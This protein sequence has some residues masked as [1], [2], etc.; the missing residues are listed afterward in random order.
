[1]EFEQLEMGKN[2]LMAAIARQDVADYHDILHPNV[3]L[4]SHFEYPPAPPIIA[5]TIP[6]IARGQ[7]RAA[8]R[9][10]AAAAAASKRMGGVFGRVAQA[11][12]SVG[13]SAGVSF[14]VATPTAAT[15]GATA[16]A[17]VEA[18][19]VARKA[20]GA[21]G[22]SMTSEKR[23]QKPKKSPESCEVDIVEGPLLATERLYRILHWMNK[24]KYIAETNFEMEV[25]KVIL[26]DSERLPPPPVPK[27]EA[28]RYAQLGRQYTDRNQRLSRL[29][30]TY[31]REMLLF[32]DECYFEDGLIVTIHRY[33]LTVQEML[34]LVGLA[35]YEN[36]PQAQ[37]RIED[38]EAER[39]NFYAATKVRVDMKNHATLPLLDFTFCKIPEP[40]HL[41]QV[42]PVAGKL[43]VLREVQ[44]AVEPHFAQGVFL[45]QQSDPTRPQKEQRVIVRARNKQGDEEV[46]EFVEESK[47]RFA[48]LR[49]HKGSTENALESLVAKMK[50]TYVAT[51][52]RI[53]ACGMVS[54]ERLVPVLRRLVVNAI[55]TIRSLDLSGN[56]ISV[57]PDFSL[58][59]L[60]HLYL[61]QNK[62][63]D[64]AQV[65]GRICPLPLLSSVALH[66][67]PL[68]ETDPHY[69]T[70]ALARL[71]RHPRRM[72]KLRQ[73]DFVTLTLQ[74][75]NTAGAFELFET[76]NAKL[77]EASRGRNPG[78]NGMYP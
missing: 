30:I 11:K 65:E 34:L 61:H 19:A 32:R 53:S 25:R 29:L 7:R 70:S 67:N 9:A 58:L 71:M 76:G 36:Q 73:L 26:Q 15:A 74:D 31:G 54:T 37:K 39:E 75:Y 8:A 40:L 3:L 10:R 77:L 12:D 62:I 20:T 22:S 24:G 41:L 52:V 69:W 14:R 59:P 5:D 63:R 68:A 17:T 72:V 64:W 23:K 57:L 51:N 4:V 1:M 28:E 6:Y 38:I 13:P 43:H 47:S 46:Y 27:D 42:R 16:G 56:E 55:M 78:T 45:N 18:G 35:G 66:G 33:M 60:Q 48:F 2:C 44:P 49:D 21:R 50:S